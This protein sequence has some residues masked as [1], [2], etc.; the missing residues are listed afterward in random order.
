MHVVIKLVHGQSEDNV[1]ASRDDFGLFILRLAIEAVPSASRV[2]TAGVAMSVAVMITA[3]DIVMR[4]TFQTYAVTVAAIE[5]AMFRI[6]SLVT[7]SILENVPARFSPGGRITVLPG[8]DTEPAIAA[9]VAADVSVAL[10]VTSVI[11]G[12]AL[13]LVL[14]AFLL[15]LVN[16]Y[17][18]ETAI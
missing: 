15:L 5:K 2:V 9:V 13:A 14:D 1:E 10:L 4:I 17:E 11:T 3:V 12:F 16:V 8:I 6:T 7:E 18:L